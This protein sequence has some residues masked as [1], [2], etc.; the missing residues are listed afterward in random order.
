MNSPNWNRRTE[1]SETAASWLVHEDA[2]CHEDRTA[3]LAWMAE[4]IDTHRMRGEGSGTLGYSLLE[5]MRYC[6]AYGQF[7]GASLLGL[8]YIERSVAAHFYGAGRNDLKRAPLGD[9]LS[10][11]LEHG[12]INREQF[13]ELERIRK[14]RNAYT[15]FRPPGSEQ[16]VEYRAIEE[17]DSFYGIIEQDAIAVVEAAL[18]LSERLSF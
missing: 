10:A 18:W 15:H 6:F 12:L 8:A 3:R 11:A 14:T 5:E 13:E 7:I 4:R 9:L 17:D 1:L 16:G 2:V